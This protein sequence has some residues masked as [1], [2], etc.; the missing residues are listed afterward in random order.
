MSIICA[1]TVPHPP[2]AVP[3]VGRGREDGIESTLAAYRTVA[4][5]V[6][7]LCPETIVI[8]SPHAPLYRDY[9]QISSGPSA[10]GTFAQFNAPRPVY[11]VV[12]DEA[13]VKALAKAAEAEALDAGCEGRQTRELDHGTLVPLHFLK[14]AWGEVHGEGAGARPF[15]K[16]VR[17]GLSGLSPLE[18]YRLGELIQRTAREL[19]RRVVYIASGDCS[20]KLTEDGPYGFAPEGPVFEHELENW[21]ADADFLGLLTCDPELAERA[22]ECGLR[23]FQIMAGALDRTSVEAEVLSHEGPFGVGYL[24]SRLQPAGVEGADGDRAFAERYDEAE[25]ERMRERL[26]HEGV[27]CSLARASIEAYVRGR[28]RIE[29]ADVLDAILEEKGGDAEKRAALEELLE[30]P[31]AC[32][33]SLKEHGQLRG[34]IGTLAPTKADLAHEICGNAIS[35]ACADPRFPHVRADELGELVLDVDVLSEPEPVDFLT[36]LDPAVYGVIVSAADGRRGVL[37]PDL[38][39]VDTV[40]EQVAIAARKGGIDPRSERLFLERF[41][42]ERHL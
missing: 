13:F 17:I 8:S 25:A 22:A 30:R 16:V 27:L 29:P 15:P 36:D 18:H 7:G 1:Y 21:L 9:L 35:A 3:Q 6:A 38:A 12:Y 11:E 23:S 40:E 39:G 20:H 10:S 14:E 4:R 19:G 34:C 31:A 2:L 42:V 33:V 24:V 37:L 28:E 41:T 32:F 26:V 5:E